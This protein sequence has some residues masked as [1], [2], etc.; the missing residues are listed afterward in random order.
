MPETLGLMAGGLLFGGLEHFLF[1]ISY[2]SFPLTFI[3]FKMVKTT[4]HIYYSLYQ[5]LITNNHYKPLLITINQVLTDRFFNVFVFRAGRWQRHQ[6]GFM[7]IDE[8]ISFGSLGWEKVTG[9]RREN[10]TTL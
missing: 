1:S 8:S 10:Q 9:S 2:T 7:G 4:N 6:H 3:F 5:V